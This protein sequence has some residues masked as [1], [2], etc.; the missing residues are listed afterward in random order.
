MGKGRVVDGERVCQKHGQS[1]IRRRD[2][3]V[4]EI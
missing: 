1:E 4:K 3:Q 2:G